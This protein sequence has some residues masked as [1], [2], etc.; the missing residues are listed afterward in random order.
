M[1]LIH[2]LLR[3]DSLLLPLP[4]LALYFAEGGNSDKVLGLICRHVLFKT[5]KELRHNHGIKGTMVQVF[6][7][8]SRLLCDLTFLSVLW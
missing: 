2:L 4:D 7:L 5:S 8:I 6:L 3:S 1:F